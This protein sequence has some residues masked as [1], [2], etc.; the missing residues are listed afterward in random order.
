[1]KVLHRYVTKGICYLLLGG[2]C[3]FGL[4]SIIGT[5]GGD[6]DCGN[7]VPCFSTNFG[8]TVY[9]FG[10][11]MD[12]VVLLSDGLLVAVGFLDGNGD[13]AAL[14]GPPTSC[15]SA[16]LNQGG[17]DTDRPPDGGVDLMYMNVQGTVAVSGCSIT[18]S[19]Y[20]ADGVNMPGL[21]ATYFGIQTL[22]AYIPRSPSPENE[23]VEK[24]QEM[25]LELVGR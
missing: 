18:V 6:G 13:I 19:D 9:L 3:I 11:Q 10:S 16:D 23:T 14:A 17:V 20:I 25:L 1:M 21:T 12:P 8:T 2:V 22:S 7:P 4:M 24:I 15:V 5:G